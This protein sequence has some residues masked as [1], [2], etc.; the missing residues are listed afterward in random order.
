MEWH[1]IID[2]RDINIL[3]NDY[4]GFHDSCLVSLNYSSGASVDN[5]GSMG[6]GTSEEKELHIFFQSQCVNKVLELSFSHVK[7][8]H[9]AGWQEHYFCDIFDCYLDFRNDLV[10][11]RDDT[12]IIWADN[13][14][15]NPNE[16]NERPIL[17][18]PMTTYVIADSLK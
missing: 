4:Y 14:S 18:E 5:N 16:E 1:R 9:I 3:M 13:E 2:K 12:L 6:C 7:N 15:F 10:K 11:D 8:F 17:N